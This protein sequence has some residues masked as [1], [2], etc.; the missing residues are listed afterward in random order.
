[1]A[2]DNNIKNFTAFDI[3]R[4]HKGLLSSKERHDLEKAALD[5]PF[6]SDALEGYTTAGVD[7]TADIIELRKRLA[8]QTQEEKAVTMRAG[9]IAFP[10]L[11]AAAVVIFIAGAGLVFY[12]V[13]PSSNKKNS[14]VAEVQLN[15]TSKATGTDTTINVSAGLGSY[16]DTIAANTRFGW[17]KSD[18]PQV[19][20]NGLAATK[21]DKLSDAY[22][23]VNTDSTSY[24]NTAPNSFATLDRKQV[25]LKTD[26]LLKGEANEMVVVT[27]PP[28]AN[29]KDAEKYE[30]TVPRGITN[31][32]LYSG[33][34]K[35]G[36][37]RAF[38]TADNNN[39]Q[40]HLNVFNGRI[41]DADNNGLPFANVTNTRDNVGTYS[42][43][44]GNFTLIS[45]DSILNVQVRSIGFNSNNSQLRNN[46]A[47]GNQI[48]MQEDKSLN[49]TVMSAKK[50]NTEARERGSMKL[51]EPVPADGWSNYDAY[52]ANNLNIP[53]EIKTKKS[54]EGEVELSF[55]VDKNG[56]PINI[57][58]EKS[59][60]AKCDQEAIRL[61]KEGPKW[62]R[63]T[64]KGRTT[65]TVP[66]SNQF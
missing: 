18:S 6:L 21:I 50:P 65:V 16:R 12:L 1:M 37:K 14:P 35:A 55:E 29:R 5:D 13:N 30:T 3:E 47:V 45:T 22:L 44:R 43:A 49:E 51:E 23:N 27:K 26:S 57:K 59:L 32:D 62:K 63:K 7:T 9:R 53:E 31:D 25:Q 64:K 36:A 33:K 52:L 41:T 34:E 11:R 17:T 54:S 19:T 61:I 60:C 20:L 8:D 48:V 46:P 66:F 24:Y 4:Y 42:D 15:D 2:N 10:W 56:D 39:T 40:S 28:A 38:A 58:I